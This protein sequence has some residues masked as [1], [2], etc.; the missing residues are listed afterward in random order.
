MKKLFTSILILISGV[1]AN[2]QLTSITISGGNVILASNSSD[3]IDIVVNGNLPTITGSNLTWTITPLNI[4]TVPGG[5][6]TVGASSTTFKLQAT[7]NGVVTVT[8]VSAT[9][10]TVTSNPIVVTVSGYVPLTG[11]TTTGTGLLTRSREFGKI[12]Y[13]Y[14]PSDA[15]NPQVSYSS[16]DGC[17]LAVDNA[18]NLTAYANGVYTI[19]S[20]LRNGGSSFSSTNVVTVTGQTPFH[21]SFAGTWDGNPF[22]WP[23]T[24]KLSFANVVNYYAGGKNGWTGTE[25]DYV[26]ANAKD[27][28]NHEGTTTNQLDFFISTPGT[29]FRPYGPFWSGTGGMYFLFAGAGGPW[30]LGCGEDVTVNKTLW[31]EVENKENT[32][33]QMQINTN[34][35]TTGDLNPSGAGDPFLVTIP[36][37]TR[38]VVKLELPNSYN[39]LRAVQI[40]TKEFVGFATIYSITVGAQ[41]PTS[42]TM[43]VSDANLSQRRGTVNVSSN[44]SGDYVVN[45]TWFSI[46]ESTP[47]IA[48]LTGIT[49]T[50]AG[51]MA[52]GKGNGTVTVMGHA[53]ASSLTG[54]SVITISGQKIESITVSSPSVVTVGS[55]FTIQYNV[56]PAALADSVALEWTLIDPNTTF[57]SVDQTTGVVSTTGTGATTIVGTVLSVNDEIIPAGSLVYYIINVS[58]QTA[59]DE[60]IASQVAVYPNPVTGETLNVASTGLKIAGVQLINV[61]GEVVAVSSTSSVGVAHLPAGYYIAVISTNKGVVR[62]TIVK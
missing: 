34:S 41:E 48:T 12:N 26:F 33:L 22:G 45:K 52:T 56:S 51:I 4:A 44:L 58:N 14:E 10:S 25:V 27:K 35:Q 7:G 13:S 8:A 28:A 42:Q 37:M 49:S 18:G 57:V 3:A 1:I 2:A 30:N 21:E 46:M 50:S 62:K 17:G 38:Q 55:G 31:V 5:S 60:G 59:V 24:Y 16:S 36:G 61:T 47:G 6:G 39:R 9:N 40:R 53:F 32:P 54:M 19:T 11:F 43:V 29:S 20:T 23:N 15:T